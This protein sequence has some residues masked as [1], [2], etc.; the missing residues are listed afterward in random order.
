MRQSVRSFENS[1]R[2]AVRSFLAFLLVPMLFCSV[3][4]GKS[5]SKNSVTGKVTLN[6]KP[7]S[8][9]IAF[10]G[11]DGKEVLGPINPDG[12]YVVNDLALGDYKIVIK[13]IPGMANGNVP[14]G[15]GGAMKDASAP[16]AMGAAPPFKYAS[17][18]N[19]LTFNVAG[20]AQT[21]DFELTP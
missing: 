7:V 12:S 6:Q 17:P 10:V 18:N 4:C 11:K 15:M 16:P 14:A 9:S 13:G 5:G 8:G 1:R 2:A 19:G 20:G 21:K 3:G